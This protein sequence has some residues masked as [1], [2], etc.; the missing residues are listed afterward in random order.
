MHP[1]G[2]AIRPPASASRLAANCLA[3]GCAAAALA[4]GAAGLEAKAP[5]AAP[6][7]PARSMFETITLLRWGY[8]AFDWLTPDNPGERNERDRKRAG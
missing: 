4:F 6:Q 1:M 5:G 8:G 2:T 7:S 3:A